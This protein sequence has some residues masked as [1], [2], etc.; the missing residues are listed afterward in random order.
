M[1]RFV[2]I[3]NSRIRTTWDVVVVFLLLHT[4]IFLPLKVSFQSDSESFGLDIAVDIL[5]FI[6]IVFS[7]FTAYRI[8]DGTLIRDFDTIAFK[9]LRSWFVLDVIATFPFYLLGSDQGLELTQ[10]VRIPRLLKMFRLLRL[11]KLLRAYRLKKLF[12][13]IEH[14][15]KVHQGFLRLSKLAML[16]LCFAHV[17]CCLWFFIGVIGAEDDTVTW[18]TDPSTK[19]GG[20]QDEDPVT[21]YVASLYFTISTLASVGLGDIVAHTQAEMGY[22]IVLILAGA[23][24]FSYATAIISSVMTDMDNKAGFFRAKMSRLLAFIRHAKLTPQLQAKLLSEMLSVIMFD[25]STLVHCI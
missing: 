11:M 8:P 14:S 2:L 4:L 5:F 9:Y 23:T 16:S 10:L 1:D 6:D 17:T 18:I 12:E 21:Q 7:F 25:M 13:K 15:P 19:Y 22:T 24:L 3:P 20:L